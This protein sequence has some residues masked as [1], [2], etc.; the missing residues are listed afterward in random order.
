VREADF[1]RQVVDLAKLR[2]WKVA[3]TW[4]SIHSP[5]GWPDLFMVRG[6]DCVAAEL[7]VIGGNM[8]RARALAR[9]REAERRLAKVVDGKR[10]PST[11]IEGVPDVETETKAYELKSWET[12]PDWFHAAWEQ[13]ERCAA[14][15]GK[16]PVLVFEAR[17]PGGKNRRYYVQEES[18]AL[19]D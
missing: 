3:W 13:A 8:T 12:L 16:E 4:N 18:F 6:K 14:S 7:K 2:G 10:N 19:G 17:F 1:Q 11:G 9:S 15:V 5:K